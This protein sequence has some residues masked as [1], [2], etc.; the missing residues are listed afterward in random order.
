MTRLNQCNNNR[1]R[2]GAQ[3]KNCD[4]LFILIFIYNTPTNLIQK[5]T[6]TTTTKMYRI[7]TAEKN[8]HLNSLRIKTP[9]RIFVRL[10]SVSLPSIREL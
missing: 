10:F 3:N 1:A 8:T 6:T 5:A 9:N 7:P 4:V 2:N